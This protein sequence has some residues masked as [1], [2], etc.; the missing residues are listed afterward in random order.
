[1]GL[2]FICVKYPV[3]PDRD[4]Q[5]TVFSSFVVVT[6]FTTENGLY[7]CLKIVFMSTIALAKV[8]VF[9]TPLRNTH[10]SIRNTNKTCPP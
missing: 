6:C 4:G 1:M 8:D 2:S 5:A 3:F 7:S 9:Q 10:D